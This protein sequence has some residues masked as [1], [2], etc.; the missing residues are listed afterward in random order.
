[1]K[2]KLISEDAQRTFA[3]IPNTDDEAVGCLTAFAKEHRLSASQFTG[4]GAFRDCVLGYFDW[5][6]KDY[7]RIPIEE[8]VEVL[9]L[10]GDI[11]LND[12]EP[13]L[14][15]HVVVSKADG[16]AHGGHLLEAHVRP[17]LE[18]D[19]HRI[20]HSPAPPLGPGDGPRAHS[21]VGTRRWWRNP[22]RS[23]HLSR[24]PLSLAGEAPRAQVRRTV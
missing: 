24:A 1:M 15:T 18:G 7:T 10:L 20:A 3:V 22:Q 21:A 8:Q 16:T 17:T 4:L 12:G 6:K 14:H 11:A 23:L 9:A 19:H 2:V 5:Q 13:K